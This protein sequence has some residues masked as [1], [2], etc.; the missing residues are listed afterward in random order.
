MPSYGIG[1]H[2]EASYYNIKIPTLKN[3]KALEHF[4]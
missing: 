2:P 4:N 3:I 1:W